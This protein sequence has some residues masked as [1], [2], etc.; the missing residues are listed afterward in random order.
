MTFKKLRPWLPSVILAV[1]GLIMMIV[2][3]CRFGADTI[4][5]L[6]FAAC[7]AVPFFIPVLGLLTKREF[8]PMLSLN[9]GLLVIF[10]VYVERVFDVYSYFSGYD[11]VLHTNFGFIGT[12]MMYSLLLR[13]KGDKMSD[14]GVLAVLILSVLGLG[15]AWEIFEYTSA[16]FTGQDPQVWSGVVSDS[17]EAGYIAGNPMTDT[18]GDLMV[19]VIGSS[20][21]CIFYLIDKT[22][23]KNIFKK[24]YGEPSSANKK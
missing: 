8:S 21:F 13:W 6:Q 3:V 4:S 15:G 24:L 17:I 7:I 2:Y 1:F 14:A 23:G 16:M 9:L 22:F 19:T 12:A 18:M 20:A 10:G 11:K 5:I